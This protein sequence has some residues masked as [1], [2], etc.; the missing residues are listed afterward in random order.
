MLELPAFSI[1]VNFLWIYLFLY[2]VLNP[3]CLTIKLHVLKWQ[4]VSFVCECNQTK[5]FPPKKLLYNFKNIIHNLNFA[6]AGFL[7]QLAM[8]RQWHR[9]LKIQLWLN[10]SYLLWTKFRALNRVFKVNVFL[11]LSIFHFKQFRSKVFH[12]FIFICFVFIV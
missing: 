11:I 4:H 6:S 1:A 10:F 2:I 5:A 12:T 8:P 9:D 3:K 7:N